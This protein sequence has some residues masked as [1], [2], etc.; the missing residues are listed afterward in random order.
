MEKA[1]KMRNESKKTIR[2]HLHP[3]YYVCLVVGIFTIGIYVDLGES[4]VAAGLKGVLG[5]ICG[6]IL[7]YILASVFGWKLYK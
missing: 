6:T 2:R 3:M 7:F 5:A 4:I 1:E